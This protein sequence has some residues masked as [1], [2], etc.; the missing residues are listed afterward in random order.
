[1]LAECSP[2]G[3]GRGNK[4]AFLA[5]GWKGA[6]S[7][8]EVSRIVFFKEGAN[9]LYQEFCADM[10]AAKDQDNKDSRPPM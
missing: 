6:A 4:D 10:V 9:E 2:G 8:L 1:M 3:H 5:C 7:E